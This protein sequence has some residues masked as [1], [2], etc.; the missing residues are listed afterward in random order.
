MHTFADPP[1]LCANT[2]IAMVMRTARSLGLALPAMRKIF[3]HVN[4]DEQKAKVFRNYEPTEHDVLVATHSKSGTNWMMQMTTQIAWRGEA[5]FEHIHQL[6]AWP[7]AEFYGIVPID[8]PGP[9]EGSSVKKRAIKT[10]IEADYVPYRE[11]AAY[12]SVIRDP[13][14]VFV[15]AYHFVFGLFN[16][17]DDIT[18]EQWFDLYQ[19]PDY[20]A[21]NWAR[22]TNSYWAWRDR[23]NVL[24]LIFSD[25]KKDLPGT[26]DRV[27]EVM[28]VSLSE[29]ERA[30]V[31]ER[32]SFGYMKE[33]ERK[34]APPR[35]P[36]TPKRAQMVR[37]GKVGGSGE[38]LTREQQA[39]IDSFCMSELERLGSDFPYAETFEVV[40]V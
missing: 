36:F 23:P 32:C 8:D 2:V 40:T 22:H 24:V 37:A 29:A 15:S 6:A 1:L 9:W 14:D 35:F 5:E 31:I 33:H 3:G 26:V 13:K 12:I 17:F 7:E 34:F 28:G 16:L 18:L 27:A 25:I 21:G 30:R 11:S 10:A 38:L 39:T 20:P 4:S 19:T